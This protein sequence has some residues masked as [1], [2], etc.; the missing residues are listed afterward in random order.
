MV[1]F[2]FVLIAS[3]ELPLETEESSSLAPENV[4]LRDA[5]TS[6]SRENGVFP[7]RVKQERI[8]ERRGSIWRP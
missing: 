6:E 7:E 3:K 1:R 2:D 5:S 8:M 4:I